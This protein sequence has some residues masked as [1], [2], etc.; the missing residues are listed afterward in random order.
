M[1]VSM[2]VSIRSGPHSRFKFPIWNPVVV[3]SARINNTAQLRAGFRFKQATSLLDKNAAK[4]QGL[5]VFHLVEISR[6]LERKAL[7]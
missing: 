2:E 1:E 4:L 7:I 3:A 6:S 5:V